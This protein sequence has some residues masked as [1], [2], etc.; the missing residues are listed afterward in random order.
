MVLPSTSSSE[1]SKGRVI[2]KASRASVQAS[3]VVLASQ[4]HS[5]SASSAAGSRLRRRLSKIFQRDKALSGL[6]TWPWVPVCSQGTSHGSSCQSPRI[7]RCRR[8]LSAL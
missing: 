4:P 6:C 7:Q 5:S 3:G 8:L 2:S 1:S